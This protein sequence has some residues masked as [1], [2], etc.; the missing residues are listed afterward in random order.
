MRAAIE[1]PGAP[2]AWRA[3]AEHFQRSGSA[4]WWI[5]AHIRV[6]LELTRSSRDPAWTVAALQ[7]VKNLVE[8]ARVQLADPA[9]ALWALQVQNQFD[10]SSTRL[11]DPRLGELRQQVTLQQTALSDVRQRLCSLE[12]E[13]RREWL[14][15]LAG[16]LAGRPDD[17]GEYASVLRELCDL[18]PDDS[19]ARTLDLVLERL[20][21]SE[22]LEVLRRTRTHKV[23]SASSAE[24]FAWKRVRQLAAANQPRLAVAIC[25]ELIEHPES[26][27]AAEASGKPSGELLA[28][29]AVCLAGAVN[30]RR[31]RA[32]AAQHLAVRQSGSLRAELASAASWQLYAL[33]ETLEAREAALD[34]S[35]AG[36]Q[37]IAPILALSNYLWGERD[38]LARMVWQRA[39]TIGIP[40]RRVFEELTEA[41]FEA[42]EVRKAVRYSRRWLALCP[43]DV[44]ARRQLL[45]FVTASG[46]A[47][48]IVD[49]VRWMVEQPHEL[50][51]ELPALLRALDAVSE[52]TAEAAKV[53]QYLLDAFGAATAEL[54]ERVS[55]LARRSQQTGLLSSPSSPTSP[56]PASA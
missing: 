21:R 33:G 39:I 46:D 3:L 7:R 4:S 13:A 32:R 16:V 22:E 47:T 35:R 56:A 31:A 24:L 26:R 10:P 37:F 27:F 30:D 50:S 43:G 48:Q 29:Y 18:T 25:Q 42:G 36:P 40:A 52:H 1:E 51:L 5:E 12:G 34:G 11:E 54:V 9:L 2:E 23:A 41:L 55:D 20:G 28:S 6:G 45:R 15:Q 44:Q 14:T 53:S 19:Y 17:A 49:V 8:I 38:A